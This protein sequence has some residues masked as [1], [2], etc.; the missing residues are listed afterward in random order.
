MAKE[1]IYKSGV[2]KCVNRFIQSLDGRSLRDIAALLL[3]I[4]DT[5]IK[6]REEMSQSVDL[7]NLEQYC[8]EVPDVS[9]VRGRSS[10]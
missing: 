6:R 9:D 3:G 4:R 7:A 2:S 10:I 8:Q 1:Y 5:L